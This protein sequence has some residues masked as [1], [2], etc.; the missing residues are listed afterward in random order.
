MLALKANQCNV[1]SDGAGGPIFWV[2]VVVYWEDVSLS[3][4]GYPLVRSDRDVALLSLVDY[5]A[6]GGCED[7]IFRNEC[8]GA[9]VVALRVVLQIWSE[10]ADDVGEFSW[11]DGFSAHDGCH[12][13][14]GQ[15]GEEACNDGLH[16]CLVV[17]LMKI[18]GVEDCVEWAWS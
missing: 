5:E 10:Y 8:A 6:V 4:L 12:G 18:V 17:L 3:S 2:S 9:L 16:G 15:Q 1:I 7:E 14:C 11:R 13:G